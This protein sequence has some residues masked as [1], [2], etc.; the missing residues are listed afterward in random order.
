MA[1]EVQVSYP[2]ARKY[3]DVC[4]QQQGFV[5][6]VEGL[7]NGSC[8][9]FG[10]FTGFMALFADAYRNAHAEVSDELARAAR[11]AGDM[12]SNIDVVLDDLRATDVTSSRDMDRLIVRTTDSPG[13]DGPPGGVDTVPG[14]PGPLK[15]ANA[16]A[17]VLTN[18]EDMAP[19]LPQHLPD[20]LPGRTPPLPDADIR[21]L[22]TDG[23]EVVSQ[24]GD[25]MA[26]GQTI[27]AAERDEDAY[28]DFKE[29]HG[30]A[31]R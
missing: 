12:G 10:A 23:L 25:T 11:G 28:E 18:A 29:R 9:N 20:G 27:G 2:G 7:V 5:Q 3:A 15:S 19:H 24:V 13:Y 14:V 22:P 16:G 8:A 6:A 30:G 1:D 4:R 26:A 17:G 31:R 21:G